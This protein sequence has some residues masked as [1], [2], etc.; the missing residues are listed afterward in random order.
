MKRWPTAYSPAFGSVTPCAAI[1]SRKKRSRDL[2]E[3][4][5][6][7]AHQRIGADGAAMGQVFE[8]EQAVL[9]DLVR[10]L[11]LHMGDEADAAGIMLVA[12]IVKTLSGGQAVGPDCGLTWPRCRS[13]QRRP[14]VPRMACDASSSCH[15]VLCLRQPA[16]RLCGSRSQIFCL[17]VRAFSDV[18]P[19][20]G[21]GPAACRRVGAG[22]DFDVPRPAGLP[23][24][25]CD[26]SIYRNRRILQDR[27]PEW[28]VSQNRTA[29]LSY[30]LQF[31]PETSSDGKGSGGKFRLLRARCCAATV[32]GEIL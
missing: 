2:H 24:R 23:V 19:V 14:S 26:G 8:H 9:D 31:M 18:A 22:R 30:L 10:L 20:D 17:A 5:G 6:A 21:A 29:S 16:F 3:H 11:A 15:P 4:A 32:R 28:Q 12:R 1:S 7:V 27:L 13:S 25:Q